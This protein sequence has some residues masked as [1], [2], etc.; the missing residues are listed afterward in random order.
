MKKIF[1]VYGHYDENSFNAAIRDT[2]T[3]S[4]KKNGYVVIGLYNKIGR[5]RTKL[6]KYLQLF[7]HMSM[8][9]K[10]TGCLSY[11]HFIGNIRRG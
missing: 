2:F 7:L 6:R 3:K 10:Q 4:V 8:L 1:V 11:D 9:T 5:L